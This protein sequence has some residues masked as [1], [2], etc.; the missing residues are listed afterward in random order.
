MEMG[1][2]WEWDDDY[3]ITE[4]MKQKEPKSSEGQKRC[5][6]G[7]ISE[8]EYTTLCKQRREEIYLREER[9]RLL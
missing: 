8:Y 4:E 2:N 1:W 7:S 9:F 5:V 6:R 3:Y